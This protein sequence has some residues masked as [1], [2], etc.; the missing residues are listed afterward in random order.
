MTITHFGSWKGTAIAIR[1][2]PV[3][4]G[5]PP[6]A[7]DMLPL[8]EFTIMTA[9]FSIDKGASSLE[10]IEH[11]ARGLSGLRFRSGTTIT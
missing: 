5:H 8:E 7:R 2:G 4:S 9:T 1:S 6:G 3:R 10:A 11:V